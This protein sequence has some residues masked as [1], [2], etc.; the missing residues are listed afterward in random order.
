MHSIAWDDGLHLGIPH[1]DDEHRT[2]VQLMNQ[3]TTHMRATSP[4]EKAIVTMARDV[5]LFTARHFLH[6]EHSMAAHH[7]PG[8]GAHK[9]EHDRLLVQLD[10]VADR[11]DRD[12]MAAIDDGLV[13]FLH[14]WVVNHIVHQD[15]AYATF[16]TQ[17]HR[18]F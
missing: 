13:E 7:Y 17:E 6:E 3:L 4:N 15:R 14:H 12:G 5:G 9:D 1:M 10:S 8:Y 16:L 18:D 2:M 11:L